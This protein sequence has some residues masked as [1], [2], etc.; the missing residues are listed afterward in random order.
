MGL[1]ENLK[2]A[3][4]GCAGTIGT[5]LARGGGGD[6]AP[7]GKKVLRSWGM[8]GKGINPACGAINPAGAEKIPVRA[9]AGAP[10]QQDAGHVAALWEGGGD[11]TK[12]GQAWEDLAVPGLGT[13]SGK[14]LLP[15]V[16]DC[17]GS[18]VE[19]QFWGAAVAHPP[20]GH[21]AGEQLVPRRDSL[22][23]IW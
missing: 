19:T 14:C 2:R 1:G 17:P 18:C 21:D 10:R 9:G 3:W 22:Q 8:N 12:D 15:P 5:A 7:W 13:G 11:V 20:Q 6:A 23:V 4:Q 16:A